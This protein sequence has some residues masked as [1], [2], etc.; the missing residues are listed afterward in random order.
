M[1]V[2][3]TFPHCLVVT[4]VAIYQKIWPWFLPT[5]W[6][7]VLFPG[8]FFVLTT[9]VGQEDLKYLH[10]ELHPVREKWYSLG[11]QLQVPTETL[12][13]IKKEHL[14]M[15]DCLLEML[16][17][18]LKRTNPPLTQEALAKALESPPLAERNLAKQLRK[19]YSQGKEEKIT[20]ISAASGPSPP[21][22]LP[23]AQGT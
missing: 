7:K 20:H 10:S 15:S 23:A 12:K 2:L 22:P 11:V 5:L 6:C 19:M 18:C 16:T 3:I 8:I 4:K 14:T 9:P 13:C 21:G 1:H 17:F